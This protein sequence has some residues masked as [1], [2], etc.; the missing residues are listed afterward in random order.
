MTKSRK[1]LPIICAIC[2]EFII[3]EQMGMTSMRDYQFFLKNKQNKVFV[4][5]LTSLLITNSFV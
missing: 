1:H 4:F 5:M 2:H 3:N